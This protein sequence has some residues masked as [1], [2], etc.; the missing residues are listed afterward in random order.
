METQMDIND[1]TDRVRR[2]SINW[3]LSM[4]KA[5]GQEV[6]LKCFDVMRQTFG[7]DLVGAVL[8]GIMEG[9]TRTNEVTIKWNG[10]PDRRVIEAIKEVR[11]LTGMGL[12]EAKDVVDAALVRDSTFPLSFEMQQSD[13]ADK[14]ERS[15]HNIEQAGFTVY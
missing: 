1:V 4:Q 15:I 14:L 13:N 9:H 5:Y 8:F 12:K 3:V 10:T 6:G 7:E 11:Y 2:T